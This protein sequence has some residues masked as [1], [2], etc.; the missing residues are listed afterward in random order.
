MCRHSH[1]ISLRVTSYKHLTTRQTETGRSTGNVIRNMKS[2]Q[3]YL[4]NLTQYLFCVQIKKSN[5]IFYLIDIIAKRN[6]SSYSLIRIKTV[7]LENQNKTQEKLCIISSSFIRLREIC[8]ISLYTEYY[9]KQIFYLM[10]TFSKRSIT[11]FTRDT[12]LMS[13]CYHNLSK[14]SHISIRLAD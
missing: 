2:S 1:V 13:I 6:P 11:R 9:L 10:A 7:T 8:R 5:F 3:R 4:Y 14:R 12:F